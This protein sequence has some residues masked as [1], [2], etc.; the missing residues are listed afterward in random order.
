MKRKRMSEYRY[1]VVD[2]T[3]REY[4]RT[5]NFDTARRFK[6]NALRDTNIPNLKVEII[7]AQRA[8]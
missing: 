7:E 6:K 8:T 5:D 1:Y 4:I 2:S 3:G